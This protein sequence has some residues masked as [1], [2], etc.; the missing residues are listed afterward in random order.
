MMASGVLILADGCF[1]GEIVRKFKIVEGEECGIPRGTDERKGRRKVKVNVDWV[2]AQGPPPLPE[3]WLAAL[4][5]G[6][7]WL[8]GKDYSTTKQATH[9]F[10]T[11][12]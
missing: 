9:L 10:V 1:E 8:D 6:G 2:G 7:S 11:V 12:K 4:R 5:K 3:S